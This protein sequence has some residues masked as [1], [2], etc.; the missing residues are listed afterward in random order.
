MNSEEVLIIEDDAR[1][2]AQIHAVLTRRG[3]RCSVIDKGDT[4]RLLNYRALHRDT[5]VVVVDLDLGDGAEDPHASGERLIKDHLWP[6]D[7][8]T[9]FVIF[10]KHLTSGA[11]MRGLGT[12]D[13][14]LARVAKEPHESI[15]GD[16]SD[17]SLSDLVGVVEEARRC[18]VA[19]I[20]L[21]VHERDSVLETVRRW[22]PIDRRHPVELILDE[23]S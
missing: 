16:I 1:H 7:R 17:K 10:S 13:P 20:P 5:R 23:R 15:S 8:S 19:S 11:G 21:I 4:A 2:Q 6:S 22:E 3:F 18:T 9:V 14:Q 12:V